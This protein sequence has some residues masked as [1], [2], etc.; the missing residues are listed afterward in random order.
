MQ[1]NLDVVGLE[2]TSAL[3]I[4]DQNNYKYSII[5]TLSPKGVNKDGECRIIHLRETNDKL[6]L[7]VSFF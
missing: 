2:L 5:E 7:I 1:K 6:E 4:L 3:Q